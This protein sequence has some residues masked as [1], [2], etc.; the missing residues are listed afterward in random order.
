MKCKCIRTYV[1]DTKDWENQ[2]TEIIRDVDGYPYMK[3]YR[4]Y[5]FCSQCEEKGVTND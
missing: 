1:G 2:E 4:D 3:V 5:C